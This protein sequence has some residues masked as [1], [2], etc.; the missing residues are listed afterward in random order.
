MRVSIVIPCLNEAATIRAAL[1]RLHC[2]RARG[3]EVIVVD[4]GS[5]DGTP[6]LAREYCDAV[7]QSPRGRAK[8][9]NVGALRA[10]GDLLLFLHAD[11]RLPDDA[12]V[13]VRSALERPHHR[14]GRF[15]VGIEGRH[16][17]LPV[18]ARL[19]NWRS[20]VTGIATG[21][22]AIFATRATFH[23]AGGFRELPLME[24]VDLS[25]RLRAVCAPVC[26]R[27]KVM[28]SG[29]RWESGGVLRTVFLMWRLRFAYWL[30]ADPAALALRY[31]HRR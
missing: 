30:G 31:E 6:E 3:A 15:N 14:W 27:Q 5:D 8:Q 10:T 4:G 19:M 22:Q 24:D 21:D 18:I 16:W 1:T 12:D 2:F 25:A 23:E 17:L 28:T 26:L 20:R 29:R 11:T 9:M 7:L 13:V